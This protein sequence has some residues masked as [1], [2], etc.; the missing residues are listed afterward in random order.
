MPEVLIYFVAISLAVAL[1][2]LLDIRRS[3]SV[4]GDEIVLAELGRN[5]RLHGDE[6]KAA[7]LRIDALGSPVLV[8]V[9]ARPRAAIVLPIPR[10]VDDDANLRQVMDVV[11]GAAERGADVDPDILAL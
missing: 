1:V 11:R 4:E 2:I 8:L 3:V 5:R 10:R 6:I 9:G 7:M